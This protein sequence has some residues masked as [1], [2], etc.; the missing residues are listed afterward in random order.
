MNRVSAKTSFAHLEFMQW[1]PKKS[2]YR[3][4][5][6]YTDTGITARVLG[7][8]CRSTFKSERVVSYRV[9][10]ITMITALNEEL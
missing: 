1:S 2:M 4:V 3:T 5:A 7:G 6:R 8:S 9:R 10:T